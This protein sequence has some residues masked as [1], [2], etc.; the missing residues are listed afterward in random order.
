[1][2]DLWKARLLPGSF[3]GIPFFIDSHELAGG[4]F[5]K[6]HNPP[7]RNSSFTEDIGKKT[8]DYKV[9]CHVMGDSYFFIRDALVNA[10]ENGSTGILIH[11]YLG[12]KTV[13][14][15]SFVLTENTKE[16]RIANF[17]LNFL[18]AGFA[19]PP[20]AA[21]EA[22]VDFAT[23]AVG[24]ALAVQSAFDVA[25][26]MAELPGFAKEAGDSLLADFSAA[27]KGG[28]KN[29]RTD[30]EQHAAL[31]KKL[32]IFN[33][34]IETLVRG[35]SEEIFNEVDSIITDLKDLVP[36]A[37]DN[38]TID[39]TS[40]RDDQLAVFNPL[41]DFTGGSA[42]VDPITPT[43]TLQKS[44]LA[45]M[46]DMIQQLAILRLSEKVVD[47]QF[48]TNDAASDARLLITEGIEAQ[49]NKEQTDDEMFQALEDLNAKLVR[50]VPNT[51]SNFSNTKE[52]EILTTIPSIMLAYD[53]Y[54]SPD[55]EQDLIDR[56]SIR[57][58]AFMS[59][60]LQVLSGNA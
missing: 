21:I 14:P 52:I 15:D 22:V 20:F 30:P 44:T 3:R 46:E 26:K 19:F 9:D 56:N 7:S 8:P 34:K 47:K 41:L 37:P 38:F 58:P 10:M 4:R 17:S 1:M 55:N 32:D 29:V 57:K 49:N 48:N 24:Y 16:G 6:K 50:A 5:V 12:I 31:N 42:E 36:V 59:G 51:N 23:T 54:E 11:P 60:T 35:E 45:S 40:G 13:K 39:S 43:R 25:Y 28:F 18:K 53:L 33:G 2:T 27:V